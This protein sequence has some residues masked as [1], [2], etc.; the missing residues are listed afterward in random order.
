MIRQERNMRC[1][2]PFV[3][4]HLTGIYYT[5]RIPKLVHDEVRFRG[6]LSL[7][8]IRGVVSEGAGIFSLSFFVD[9][10]I[11]NSYRLFK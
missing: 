7:T 10:Q 4:K 9:P 2:S 1:F 3:Q 6:P 11:I 8:Y 5:L